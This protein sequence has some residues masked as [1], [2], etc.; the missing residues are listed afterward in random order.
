[1][2]MDLLKNS[3]QHARTDGWCKHRDENL[4]KENGVNQQNCNIGKKWRWWIYW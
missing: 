3:G 1:M 4:K 2:I